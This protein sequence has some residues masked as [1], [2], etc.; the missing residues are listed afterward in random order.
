M[1][2]LVTA[3]DR[4]L[5]ERARCFLA[6]AAQSPEVA[7]VLA[8][9]GLSAEE[10]ER[11]QRLV[12]DAARAFQ[13]EEAGAAWN[14]LS[15]TP[16]RRLAEA[17]QWFRDSRRRHLRECLRDAE[18]EAGWTGVRPASRWPL[19]RKLTE[20]SWLALTHALRAL[21]PRALLEARAELRQNLRRAR[22][23]RPLDA[24]PPKDTALAELGGWYERW[25]LLAQRV[26]RQNPELLG[27]LGLTAGK[28]PPRLRAPRAREEFGE[29]AAA[30]AV[31]DASRAARATPPAPPAARPADR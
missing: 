28:A 5:V 3:Y 20:G 30:A 24:P 6:G 11:G 17:K 9:F 2:V 29:G 15:P 19:Q 14:F 25:R 4:E 13:W 8:G 27:V 7:S 10:R 1:K 23:P 22:G 12:E 16:E 26:F 21:S 31:T 18:E